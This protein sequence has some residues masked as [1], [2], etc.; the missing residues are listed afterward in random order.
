[1]QIKTEH[2]K[3]CEL[4]VLSGEIDSASAPELEEKLVG[5]V[6][7]GKRNLVLNFRDV[8]FI[9]SAGINALLSAQVKARRRIPGGELVISEI[10]PELKSTLELVG[11][12]HLFQFFEKDVDAVGSF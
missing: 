12:H 4:V 1:M 2:M 11:L 10:R 5:W 8:T 7:R 9:S 6:E 3:R